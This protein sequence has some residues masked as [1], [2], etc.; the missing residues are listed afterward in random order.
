MQASTPR[1]G[2][3]RVNLTNCEDSLIQVKVKYL[4]VMSIA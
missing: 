1:L 3:D 4:A 2:L